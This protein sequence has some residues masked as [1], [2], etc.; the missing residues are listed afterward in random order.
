MSHV[1]SN[2]L[3][4]IVNKVTQCELKE[5]IGVA[6]YDLVLIKQLLQLPETR[7]ITGESFRNASSLGYL[8]VDE[9]VART[10]QVVISDIYKTMPAKKAQGMMQDVYRS[11]TERDN[12]YIKFQLS[13]D[14]KA[15]LIQFKQR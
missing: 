3:D 8:S 15:V 10:L 12:L 13:K 7:I 6:T 9:I 5:M 4:R 1:H 2:P 14:R 11:K